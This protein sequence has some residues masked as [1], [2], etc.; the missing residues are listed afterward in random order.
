MSSH[1]PVTLRNAVTVIDQE[2]LPCLELVKL[3]ITKHCI[4]QPDFSVM[5]LLRTEPSKFDY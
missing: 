2:S 1:S 5:A 3:L 4:P